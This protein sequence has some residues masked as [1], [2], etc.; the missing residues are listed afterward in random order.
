[1]RSFLQSTDDSFGQLV[2]VLWEPQI[3]LA[4][5]NCRKVFMQYYLTV[6]IYTLR[7]D[8]FEDACKVDADDVYL[9]FDKNI[10]THSYT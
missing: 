6:I 8:V 9:I 1:M 5:K 7:G 4:H 10:I 2:P 3:F